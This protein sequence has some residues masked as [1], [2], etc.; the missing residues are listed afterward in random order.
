MPTYDYQCDA[1]G[2]QFEKFQSMN[3]KPVRKCPTC[4]KMKVRRLIGAGAVV[5]FKGNGFYHTDYKNKS[6]RKNDRPKEQKSAGDENKKSE[7]GKE[8]C[9]KKENA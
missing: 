5:I 8:N 1:C 6:R 9:S 3:D 2:H 7:G 4:G